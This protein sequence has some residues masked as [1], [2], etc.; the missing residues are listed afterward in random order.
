MVDSTL[1][2][3]QRRNPVGSYRRSVPRDKD[4]SAPNESPVNLFAPDFEKFPNLNYIETIYN[5]TL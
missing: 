5:E 1:D 4:E 2:W 3:V